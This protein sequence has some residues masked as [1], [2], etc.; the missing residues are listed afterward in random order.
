MADRTDPTPDAPS[1]KKSTARRASTDTSG[2]TS[3]AAEPTPMDAE[4]AAEAS[5][6]A[7][8]FSRAFADVLAAARAL[9]DEARSR[10]DAYREKYQEQLANARALL[11]KEAGGVSEKARAKA[12]RRIS[13]P[14]S[15]LQPFSGSSP[16]RASC[17]SASQAAAPP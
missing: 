8:H 4:A 10:T 13:P 17:A 14:E 3:Q 15:P 9:R 11:G 5:E 12:A 6:T 7:S 2:K 1:P 16:K